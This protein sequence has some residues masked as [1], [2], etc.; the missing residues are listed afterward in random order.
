VGCHETDKFVK[1]PS[2]GERVAKALNDG[3]A[4]F[5]INCCGNGTGTGAGITTDKYQ[6]DCA[7]S[8]ESVQTAK[9]ARIVNDANCLC[10][11]ESIV[12]P[13]LGGEMADVFITARFPDMEGIPQVVLDFWK[14]ARD[15]ASAK[16]ETAKPREIKTL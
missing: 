7:V 3:V 13:E 5:A 12:S 15:E 16:G 14:E 11:G 9:L 8:C 6:G 10:M 1:F 2:I 4:K